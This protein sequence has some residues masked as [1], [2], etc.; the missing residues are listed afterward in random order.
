[1]SFDT[2][3]GYG[4][5]HDR[6]QKTDSEKESIRFYTHYTCAADEYRGVMMIDDGKPYP[7][8]LMMDVYEA[9][10]SAVFSDKVRILLIVFIMLLG[11]FI[12][13]VPI[14]EKKRYYN[15]RSTKRIP[16]QRA[17]EY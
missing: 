12:S 2:I 7:N 15:V 14:T 10:K 17:E 11:G 13:F 1:M 8:D 9:Q 6:L 5:Y 4:H 16:N 3:Y